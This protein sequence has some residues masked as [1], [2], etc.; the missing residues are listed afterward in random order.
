MRF[1]SDC[2]VVMICT[3]LLSTKFVSTSNAWII[4]LIWSFKSRKPYLK[5]K[6]AVLVLSVTSI[7][8][9]LYVHWKYT[10][11]KIYRNFL[12]QGSW[13]LIY[14][15]CQDGTTSIQRV[16]GTQTERQTDQMYSA[17]KDGQTDRQA[18]ITGNWTR[19]EVDWMHASFP[20]IAPT[21]YQLPNLWFFWL[22]WYFIP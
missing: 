14:M 5:Q 10:V 17:Y 3:F 6:R 18:D 12:W 9:Y 16:T 8:S 13:S 22:P 2:L 21:F 7:R 20:L 1:D 15:L 4:R 19:E 11:W